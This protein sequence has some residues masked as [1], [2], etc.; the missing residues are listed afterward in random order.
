MIAGVLLSDFQEDSG[1][2]RGRWI[3][4]GCLLI[5]RIQR[6][7]SYLAWA[8]SGVHAFVGAVLF[9]GD[10]DRLVAGGNVRAVPG[11]RSPDAHADRTRPRQ[12]TAPRRNVNRGPTRRQNRAAGDVSR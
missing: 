4:V 10:H 5:R 11:L 9:S 6:T 1:E 8:L 7:G 3:L 12:L 2:S